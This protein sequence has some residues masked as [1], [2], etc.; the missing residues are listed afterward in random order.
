MSETKGKPARLGSQTFSS[1]DARGGGGGEWSRSRERAPVR[2]NPS[3][4]HFSLWCRIF[5]RR[6]GGC[7]GSSPRVCFAL[8]PIPL[9]AR[10]RQR[11]RP[12]GG[13]FH[14]SWPEAPANWAMFFRRLR[15]QRRRLRDDS[16]RKRPAPVMRTLQRAWQMRQQPSGLGDD[17]HRE[18]PL[19]SARPT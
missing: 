19:S 4:H 3:P 16:D 14:R 9:R 2:S 7:P 15:P 11:R 17:R 13:R 18:F 6:T 8:A 5:W 10:A 12:A 1:A